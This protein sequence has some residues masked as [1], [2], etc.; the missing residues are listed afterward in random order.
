MNIYKDVFVYNDKYKNMSNEQIINKFDKL[1]NKRIKLILQFTKNE[2]KEAVLKILK[3][4]RYDEYIKLLTELKIIFPFPEDLLNKMDEIQ[5]LFKTLKEH[6][7]DSTTRGY[8]FIMS[9]ALSLL[10]DDSYVLNRGIINLPL[11][12]IEHQWLEHNDKVYD[13][14]L[15]LI[16]PKEYY[17]SIYKPSNLHQLTEEEIEKIKRDPFNGIKKKENTRK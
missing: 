6:Y 1:W 2:E 8:C 9:T 5:V 16:F 7:I 17:Y 3:N 13:T 4:K 14:T 12:S 11:I 10:F 15:H